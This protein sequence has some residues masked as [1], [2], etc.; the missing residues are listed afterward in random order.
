MS[1]MLSRVWGVVSC[2]ALV[3]LDPAWVAAR[4]P[5]R[6]LQQ[7]RYVMG[8]LCEITVFPVGE[9]ATLERSSRD[10]ERDAGS[11]ID[12]AY[13]E[14]RR[15]DAVLS[16]WNPHSELMRMNAAA[17]ATQRP[18]PWVRVSGELFERVRTALRMAEETD[19]LFDPTVGPLVRAWGF[20][21]PCPTERPCG[22]LSRTKAI[23]T[24]RQRVGW[25]HVRMDAQHNQIQF[26]LSDM[27]IDLGG[28]AKG[29]A[30]ERAVQVLRD[31]G[32]ASALVNLGNSSLKALGEPPS[33]RAADPASGYR[34]PC[35]GWP[36]G[37]LDPRDGRSVAARICMASGE[38]IATSGTYEHVIGEGKN[39][40]SHLIDPYTG[41][42]LG[43]ETGVTV[44]TSDAEVADALTKPFILR[45]QLTTTAA[46]GAMLIRYPG[47]GVVVLSSR[48]GRLLEREAGSA[49]GRVTMAGE[50]RPR[51][52][53][54]RTL[55]V[56]YSTVI[57]RPLEA[58]RG[59]GVRPCCSNY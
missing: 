5:G 35:K 40:R 56:G 57:R 55:T 45:P 36:I 37:V 11:A 50:R 48:G 44:L 1:P 34:A 26:E 22:S 47:T 33:A 24:A 27:E 53:I 23:E 15:I 25:H 12:A 46:G 9:R 28:I 14:L 30:V 39:R 29:Y 8:T 13:A 31:R 21:P 10:R 42:A 51:S 7:V 52:S 6:P 17:N 41:D 54:R 2:L 59:E 19:G 38:A 20:L 58:D 49:R 43:G 4:P 3:C 32:I 16:N 18:R